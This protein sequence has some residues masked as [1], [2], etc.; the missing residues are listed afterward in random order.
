MQNAHKFILIRDRLQLYKDFTFNL[1]HKIYDFYLDPITLSAKEDIENHF[2]WCYNKSCNDFE[3]EEIYFIENKN[4]RE[5]FY[6]Y[7]FNQLYKAPK[8]PSL[9]YFEIFWNNI[10]ELDLKKNKN[11]IG[12]LVEIYQIFDTTLNKEKILVKI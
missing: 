8:I 2:N 10:F 6:A 5:Y 1:L 9:N 11:M 12:A 7:F 3:K 4:L